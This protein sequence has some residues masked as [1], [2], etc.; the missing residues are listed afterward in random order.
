M[1]VSIDT[2]PAAAS[3]YSDQAI[4]DAFAIGKAAGINAYHYVP[5]WSELEPSPGVY[6]FAKVDRFM[7]LSDP[8][9]VSLNIRLI[10]AGKRNGPYTNRAWTDLSLAAK[11]KALLTALKSHLGTRPWIVALGNE[12][13]VYF[14]TR[15]S[16]IAG[17]AT[18]LSRVRPTVKQLFGATIP[19]TVNFQWWAVGKFA[20]EYAPIAAQCDVVS[21]TY[22][23]FTTGFQMLNPYSVVA[24]VET[25]VRASA[26]K[27]VFF[28]EIGYASGAACGGSESTQSVFMT[29]A[30]AT[31]RAWG[32]YVL[33]AS[34]LFQNEFPDWLMENMKTV[35]GMSDPAWLSYVQTLGLHRQD[36]TAKTGWSTLLEQIAQTPR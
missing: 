35:Y 32:E 33:G 17:F 12:V 9:P 25:I 14:G 28:Q 31:L 7:A 10:D 22:Y 6:D 26:P 2:N 5:T 19:V 24:D 15:Q 20:A 1:K 27:F 23:P 11:F 21:V 8:L 30:F 16:E 29:Y 18:F 36:G 3:D 34:V 4:A 13:D